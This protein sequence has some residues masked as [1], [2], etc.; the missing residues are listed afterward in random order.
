MASLLFI[1]FA[2]QLALHLLNTLGGATINQIL[3]VLYNKLPTPT[4]K[5]THEQARLKREVLRLKRELNGVSAQD[6]FA[7]WAKLRRQYDKVAADFEKIDSSLR[8]VQTSFNATVSSVRW[9]STNGVRFFLQ[10]WYSKQPLFW[11]P[12]GWVPG[13]AEWILAFPRAP[14]GSVS[15]NIWDIA[16]AS[17]IGLVS[18]AIVAVYVLVMKQAPD[19]RKEKPQAFVAA[20]AGGVDQRKEQ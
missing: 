5:V 1:V 8:S 17:I 20:G 18:E 13:Y 16:C 11:I 7:R 6:D 9:L 19:Q 14:R 12:R 3:W 15:I 10:F 4:A 2:I